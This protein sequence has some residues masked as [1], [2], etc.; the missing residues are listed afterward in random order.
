MNGCCKCVYTISIT[1]EFRVLIGRGE[2][3]R[4]SY[5]KEKRKTEDVFGFNYNF[6]TPLY[7]GRKSVS[8]IQ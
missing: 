8:R 3:R 4:G 7:F 1:S 5:H 6:P 2:V